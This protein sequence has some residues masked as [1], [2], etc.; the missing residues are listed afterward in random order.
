MR[1]FLH[2]D[3]AAGTLVTWNSKVPDPGELLRWRGEWFYVGKRWHEME[4]GPAVSLH[5]ELRKSARS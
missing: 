1:V 2:F 4:D 3:G 5:I